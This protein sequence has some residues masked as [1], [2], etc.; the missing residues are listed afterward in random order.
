MRRSKV[1]MMKTI[2]YRAL[3]ILLW[4]SMMAALIVPSVA[5]AIEIQISRQ[6]VS[7]AHISGSSPDYS[8]GGTVGEPV[9]GLRRAVYGPVWNIEGR[10]LFQDNFALGAPTTGAVRMDMALDILPS[11]NPNI[12][13]GDSLV[14]EVTANQGIHQ[15]FW[16]RPEAPPLAGGLGTDSLSGGAAVYMHI[17]SSGGQAGDGLSGDEVRWPVLDEQNGWT[18]IRFDSAY[19]DPLFENALPG[20]YCV[21]LNDNLFT[22][23]DRIDFYFSAMDANGT[24]RYWSC[25]AGTVADVDAARAMPMEV[26]CLPTGQSDILYVDD[27]DDGDGQVYFDTAFEILGITP[28]R[29]DVRSPASLAGNGLG[30]RARLDHIIPWYRTIIWNCG[31]HSVGTIG[32]GSEWVEKSPDAQLLH[33]FLDQS[34]T[35]AGLYLSGDDVAEE[36]KQLGSQPAEELLNYIGYDVVDGDHRNAGHTKTPL[37]A[38]SGVVF[39]DI[40]CPDSMFV[41]GGGPIAKDFDVLQPTGAATPEMYYAPDPG[42][43][44]MIAQVAANAQGGLAKVV[45]SGASFHS[46]RDDRPQSVPERA[47]H[48]YR[49]LLWLENLVPEPTDADDAP[50]FVNNL[51]QN[52]PNPFNPTTTIAF[53]LKRKGHV[54]LVI[55]DVRGRVVKRLLCGERGPGFYTDLEWGGLNDHGQE[56]ASGV[57]FYR[58]TAPGFMQTRKMVLVK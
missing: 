36:L 46:I 6:V 12:R 17:R 45:L 54:E 4:A 14:V 34:I 52:Y 49:I 16:F 26:Q 41:Y 31:D 40:H 43:S 33:G 29:F 47:Q 48:L 23:P 20:K 7:S 3:D 10:H 13:P 55:Y 18:T 32:D 42:H 44:A 2:S 24:T 1:R 15:G 57:Y 37:L 8:T 5:V 38:A 27:F 28:D 51:A 50:A 22:S 21:D 56:V 53:S 25:D 35:T 19:A 9:V 30:S 39:G 58:L 11:A